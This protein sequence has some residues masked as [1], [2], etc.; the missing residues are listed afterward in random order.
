[1]GWFSVAIDPLLIYLSRTL[2]GI[3]ICSLPTSGPS[4]VD[5]TPPSPVTELYKVFGFAEDVKPGVKTMAEF[6]LVDKAAKLFSLAL[7]VL[8]IEIQ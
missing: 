1:M 7:D 5:G 3:P 4:L 8:F 6:A 2:S